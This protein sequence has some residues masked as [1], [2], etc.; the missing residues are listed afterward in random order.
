MKLIVRLYILYNF[1]AFISTK[2]LVFGQNQS[3]ADSLIEVFDQRKIDDSV[4]AVLS[5]MIAI[6]HGKPIEALYY[7]QEFLRI[8]K[9][10]NN[11]LMQAEAYEEISLKHRILGDNVRAFEAVFQ[12]LS[13]YEELDLKYG[14]VACFIQIGSNYIVDKEY[15]EAVKYLTKALRINYENN[16]SF[17][18]ALNHINLGEAYRLMPLPDSAIY[19]FD[20]AIS[21]NKKMNDEIIEG[22]A[23]G[24]LGMV[25]AEYGQE[26]LG[27]SEME[28]ATGVLLQLGD[29][30]SVAVYKSEIGKAQIKLGQTYIGEENILEGLAL[31]KR[32]NLKEQIRDISSYLSSYYEKL[33]RYDESLS[34]QREFQTY[35]DSLVNKENI[36][37]IEQLK[38]QY[39]LDKKES[40]IDLL[41][42]VNANQR[43]IN[44]LLI[45]GILLFLALIVLLFKNNLHRRKAN[46]KLFNQKEIIERREEEKALLLKELNHRVKNNLQMISSLLNLQSQQLNDHPAIE[47]IKAGR[48]RVEA[49]SLIHQKLYQED[50]HTQIEMKD[51]IEELV[52]N[53]IYSYNREIE[54]GLQVEGLSIDIDYAIPI[55]LIINE[56]VT[57]ALKYAYENIESPKL[58]V[59]LY[60]EHDQLH[61]KVKDNGIGIQYVEQQKPDSFGLKLVKSLV[62]QLDGKIDISNGN[63]TCWHMALVKEKS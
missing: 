16:D 3:K 39:E 34:Y 22:Y 61:L 32:E 62:N 60:E 42:Q 44:Y 25:H 26:E 46:K 29:T 4:G 35:Q 20:R 48:Y 24:N 1:V 37:K 17:N 28:R 54:L 10:I 49:M 2:A 40:E 23:L 38:A 21:L 56:L 55:A 41:N 6:R 31:A 52:R 57:N 5:K 9:Q 8:S 12:A 53:L 47:A 50:H 45:A 19:N 30:Y 59:R 33:S 13:I 58:E 18:I 27:I 14:Q 15:N 7:A 63:G 51:Y 36:Q 11:K 43:Y